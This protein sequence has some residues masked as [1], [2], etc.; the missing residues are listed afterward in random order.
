[1]EKGPFKK[2]KIEKELFDYRQIIFIQGF[3][4]VVLDVFLLLNLQTF[5]KEIISSCVHKD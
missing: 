5:A 3:K 4:E 1:M 2:R